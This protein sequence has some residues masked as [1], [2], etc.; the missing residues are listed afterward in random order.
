M[1][2]KINIFFYIERQYDQQITLRA[3]QVIEGFE[4]FYILYY[5]KN[6]VTIILL[7][8]LPQMQF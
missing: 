7:E 3:P 1:W 2:S 8:E 4:I 5:N 6:Y